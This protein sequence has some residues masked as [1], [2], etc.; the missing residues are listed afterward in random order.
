MGAKQE[1]D[2]RLYL[3]EVERCLCTA[4]MGASA[5]RHS[6]SQTRPGRSILRCSP[7]LLPS[8]LVSLLPGKPTT[9]LYRPLINYNSLNG[10]LFVNFRATKMLI[11]MHAIS[12]R[13]N[14]FL[15]RSAIQWKRSLILYSTLQSK[16]LTRWPER[17][18]SLVCQMNK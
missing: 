14:L 15:R 5:R 12:W 3:F 1:E 2:V 8:I 7:V 11:G 4:T 6:C 16:Q 9:A 18:P 13:S 10:R 17:A